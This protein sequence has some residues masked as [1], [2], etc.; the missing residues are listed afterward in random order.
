MCKRQ[1]INGGMQLMIKKSEEGVMDFI[2]SV[3]GSEAEFVIEKRL[4]IS[5]V[6]PN[7]GRLLIPVLQ[8]EN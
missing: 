4:T 6:T 5:D 7:K 2:K 8:V 1:K 3:G